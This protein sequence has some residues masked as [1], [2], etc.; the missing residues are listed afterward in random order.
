VAGGTAGLWEF[1]STALLCCAA[2]GSEG[3]VRGTVKFKNRDEKMKK[4]HTAR[5]L[6]SAFCFLPSF[7]WSVETPSCSQIVRNLPLFIG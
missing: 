2:R 1:I 7:S 5:L 6:I 3:V 4:A